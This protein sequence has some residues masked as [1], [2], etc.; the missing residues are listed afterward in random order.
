[1]TDHDCF[2]DQQGHLPCTCSK[3]MQENSD[4]SDANQSNN[5][6]DWI[7]DLAYPIDRALLIA[8]ALAIVAIAYRIFH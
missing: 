1:M 3:F 6:W 2:T 5:P 4:G 8:C 7:D